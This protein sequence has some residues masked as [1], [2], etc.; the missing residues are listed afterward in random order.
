M[1][2]RAQKGLAML[3]AAGCLGTLAAL[4]AHAQP[5]AGEAA[6]SAARRSRFSAGVIAGYAEHM[7]YG[8]VD[9]S[10]DPAFSNGNCGVLGTG[11]GGGLAVGL[12]GEFAIGDAA[13]GL[14]L[15]TEP[16][17]GNMNEVAPGTTDFRR[18]DGSLVALDSRDYLNL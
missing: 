12:F 8:T 13:I 7:H 10:A 9:L 14:R 5:A 15:L 6:D 3:A 4:P 2:L 16:S 18:V 11:F 17:S 1:K